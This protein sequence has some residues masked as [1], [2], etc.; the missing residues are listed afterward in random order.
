[1]VMFVDAKTG[2][3]TRQM[4]VGPMGRISYERLIQIIKDSGELH[5]GE[6]ITHLH[7]KDDGLHYRT[8]LVPK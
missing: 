6:E 7:F 5:T 8:E 2:E 3:P 4:P 1:M